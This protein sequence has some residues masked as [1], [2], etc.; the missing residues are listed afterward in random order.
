M[1]MRPLTAAASVSQ[2][3]VSLSAKRPQGAPSVR[4]I[5]EA[6]AEDRPR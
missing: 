6:D 3:G 4:G 1:C 5:G 2:T